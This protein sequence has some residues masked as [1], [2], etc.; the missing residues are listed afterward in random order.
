[1][2]LREEIEWWQLEGE[3]TSHE[4]LSA[5]DWQQGDLHEHAYKEIQ[6]HQY[7]FGKNKLRESLRVRF[8]CK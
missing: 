4:L 8:L 7:T 3:S 6:A 1:M 2:V 5:S